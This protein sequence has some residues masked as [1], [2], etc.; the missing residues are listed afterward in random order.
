MLKTRVFPEHNYKGLYLNGRTLRL[1][2]DPNK[3]ITEL[4]YPEFFDVKVTSQCKGNC[5]YC[6]TENTAINTE[7]KKE[8]IKNI[9]VNDKIITFNE[10]INKNEVNSVSQVYKRKYSGDIIEIIL[11]NNDIIEITPNH[12]VYVKN[13]GYIRADELSESDELLEI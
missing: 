4:S 5:P 9:K 1:A 8:L 2:L 3:P 11:E 13:K 6:F 10:K 12:E 7:N